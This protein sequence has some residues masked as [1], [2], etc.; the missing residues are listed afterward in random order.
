MLSR[1][2]SNYSTI[3]IPI[4]DMMTVFSPRRY[5]LARASLS[6]GDWL[7]ALCC[8]Y[9]SSASMCGLWPGIYSESDNGCRQQPPSP[10]EMRSYYKCCKYLKNWPHANSI[11][12]PGVLLSGMQS[13]LPASQQ[14]SQ[15]QCRHRHQNVHCSRSAYSK[16]IQQPPPHE[17]CT[18]NDSKRSPG[19]TTS[20]TND[21]SAHN[22]QE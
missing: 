7:Y 22:F 8:L 12:Q 11:Y 10:S 4:S 1:F 9:Y 17:I 3:N 15:P 20:T 5:S 13:Q 16:C 14:A 6:L 18:W 2:P 19:T 21:E